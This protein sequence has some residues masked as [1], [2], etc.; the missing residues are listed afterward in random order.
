MAITNFFA[1]FRCSLCL[2]QV[3]CFFRCTWPRSVSFDYRVLDVG[4]AVFVFWGALYFILFR[5]K[6]GVEGDGL[7]VFVV[8]FR[9]RVGDDI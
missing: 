7:F 2:L 8:R 5:P 3:N 9:L 1:T 4:P 6:A